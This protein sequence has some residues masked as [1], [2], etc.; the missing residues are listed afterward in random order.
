MRP[1]KEQVDTAIRSVREDAR[2]DRG[3][4][5]SSGEIL[6]AEVE[7]LR[8]AVLSCDRFCGRTSGIAPEGEETRLAIA[9]ERAKVVRFL[10]SMGEHGYAESIEEGAHVLRGGGYPWGPTLAPAITCDR[11]T[12]ETA[13]A[14]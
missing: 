3:A 4:A 12:G 9:D 6:A 7:A 8:L 14:A 10:R 13:R 1:T 2:R 5:P 11:L